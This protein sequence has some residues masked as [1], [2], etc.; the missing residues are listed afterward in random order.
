MT[1]TARVPSP[2][3]PGTFHQLLLDDVPAAVVVTDPD[4]TI[5]FWN[6]HAE[7]IYG[8]SRDEAI[9]RN[10]LEVSTSPDHDDEVRRIMATLRTGEPWRGEITLV[11]RDGRMLPVFASFAPQ[12]DEAGAMI[13]VVS[14]SVDITERRRSEQRLAAQTAVTRALAEAPSLADAAPRILQD[15]ARRLGWSACLLWT[16]DPA[17]ATLRLVGAWHDPSVPAAELVRFSE[18]A[19]FARGAGVP[20]RVWARGEAIWLPDFGSDASLPRAQV[21]R[22]AGLHAALAFPIRLGPQVLGVV[23]LFSDEDEMDE[24]DDELLATTGAIGTLIGQFID[25]TEEEAE[26]KQLLR[27]AEARYRTLVE[28]TP[29]VSYTNAIGDPSVCRYVSP[30]IEPLTG[31]SPEE[32]MAE[33]EIWLRLVH[34][35]DREAEIAKDALHNVTREPYRSEYRLIGRDGREVWVRD[36][37]VIQ[38]GEDG[39]PDLWQGVMVDVTDRKLT[40]L[41]LRARALQQEA[42]ADLG[43]L[44]LTGADVPTVM[45]RAMDTVCD[46]LDLAHAELL[47]LQAGGEFALRAGRG[48]GDEIGRAHV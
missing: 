13:G 40:E 10:L 12:R 36:Q 39:E 5:L 44:A 8:W 23:E 24:P 19:A 48:W 27:D 14:V 29:V 11:A 16:V 35:E 28:T 37:A 2:G 3:V 45:E 42:V 41:Q 1:D 17:S 18:G 26:L 47:E 25:R 46:T 15:V 9:G 7:S 32:W 33:P 34:P 4:G 43:R 31:Y 20:G 21:V 6:R 22:E 30:Q 38:P